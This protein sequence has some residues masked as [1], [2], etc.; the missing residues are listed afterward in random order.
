MTTNDISYIV[1]MAIEDFSKRYRTKRH[2]AEVTS[3]RLGEHYRN[4]AHLLDSS[5]RE[6]I[7]EVRNILERIAE[8]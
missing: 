2:P 7:F 5:E 6:K 1:D 8:G 4:Y 3:D